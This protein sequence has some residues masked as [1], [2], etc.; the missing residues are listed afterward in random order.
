VQFKQALFVPNI[1]LYNKVITN[2]E[3]P[4]L[5]VDLSWQLS[6]QKV[7]ENL[8]KAEKGMIMSEIVLFHPPPPREKKEQKK[9]KPLQLLCNTV[10]VNLILC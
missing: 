6:L 5:R 4:D 2:V 8:S 7:W 3:Q 9:R 10:I 1:S